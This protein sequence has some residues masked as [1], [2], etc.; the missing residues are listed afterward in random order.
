MHWSLQNPS[1]QLLFSYRPVTNGSGVKITKTNPF[2]LPPELLFEIAAFLDKKT[3]IFSFT[4][5][6]RE[7]FLL[8]RT[9]Q[10][11]LLLTEKS[12]LTYPTTEKLQSALQSFFSLF[13]RSPK[14]CYRA[15][16][17]PNIIHSISFN[18]D[19]NHIALQCSDGHFDIYDSRTGNFIEKRLENSDSTMG[20]DLVSPDNLLFATF[21]HCCVE[22]YDLET[23]ELRA[24]LEGHNN[25]VKSVSFSADGKYVISVSYCWELSLACLAPGS[26]SAGVIHIYYINTKK[27]NKLKISCKDD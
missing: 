8:M 23:R 19:K 9:I 12:L 26:I 27:N 3:L 10:P 7:I 5:I 13:A 21:Y 16:R 25:D 6:S 18:P 20:G 11:P 15:S 1:G 14:N 2:K 4:R 24:T 17:D 22:L